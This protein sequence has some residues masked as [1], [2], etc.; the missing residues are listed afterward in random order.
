MRHLNKGRYLN[1]SASHRRA[2]LANLSQELFLHKRIQTTL[3]KARELRPFAEKLI[4]KA[5]KG[6]LAARRSI[7]SCIYRD[8]AVKMLFDEVAPAFAERNGGYTRIIKMGPRRGDAAALAIIELVGFEG[9]VKKVE[10]TAAKAEKK[11]P[12]VKN[13]GERK[14]A[15][16]KT[17]AKIEGAAAKSKSTAK[18]KKGSA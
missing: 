9:A 5:K 8:S 13:S 14:A 17:G 2:L 3:G 18:T 6:T 16:K 4:T 11:T 15:P 10:G 1:R 7:S 12:K